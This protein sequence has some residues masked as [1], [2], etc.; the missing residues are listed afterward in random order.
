MNRNWHFLSWALAFS[1]I[2]NKL[3]VLFKSVS[4]SALTD[5]RLTSFHV[6]YTLRVSQIVCVC[7]PTEKECGLECNL[8][9]TDTGDSV[10]VTHFSPQDYGCLSLSHVFHGDKKGPITRSTTWTDLVCVIRRVSKSQFQIYSKTYNIDR[11][12]DKLNLY[13]FF[14]FF[15]VVP[16]VV[17]VPGFLLPTFSL[18]VVEDTITNDFFPS[19]QLTL[20]KRL[21]EFVPPSE[22]LNHR[23][24]WSPCEVLNREDHIQNDVSKLRSYQTSLVS[25]DQ[26]VRSRHSWE[27]IGDGTITPVDTPGDVYWGEGVPTPGHTYIGVIEESPGGIRGSLLPSQSCGFV[28]GMWDW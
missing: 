12:L 26:E 11:Y 6:G 3:S 4:P 28:T 20:L 25:P 19:D 7:G 8:S 13:Y 17:S 9:W 23:Q 5:N 27:S 16:P 1:V 15:C 10:S 18:H 14:L 21:T 24:E 22:S 2:I